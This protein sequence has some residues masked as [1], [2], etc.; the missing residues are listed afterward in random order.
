MDDL[1]FDIEFFDS[2]GGNGVVKATVHK[3]GKLGFNSG[4]TKYMKLDHLE[5][6]NIG[7]NKADEK[8]DSLYLVPA[9]KQNEKTYKLVKAGQYY[10]LYIK[11]IL[12]DMKIDYKN[13]NII[14][15]IEEI[16][17]NGKS[18]YKLVRRKK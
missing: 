14:Y 6:F 17:K 4:A 15:D 2:A 5:F 16:E 12:R 18:I 11:N 13:E 7:V 3:T 8:D 9:E 1:D 10:Y